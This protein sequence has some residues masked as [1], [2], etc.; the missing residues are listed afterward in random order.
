MD[1]S[2][3]DHMVNHWFAEFKRRRSSTSDQHRSGRSKEA[4]I[5]EIAD[6]IHDISLNDPKVKVR[7]IAEAIGISTGSVV[8]GKVL[9]FVFLGF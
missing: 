3:S 8:S 2:P 9:A 4:P 1:S 6:K 7:E 5:P